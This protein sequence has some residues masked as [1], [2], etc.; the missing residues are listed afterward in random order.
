MIIL[1]LHE[2]CDKMSWESIK[3]CTLYYWYERPV[4][5]ESQI[6]FSYLLMDVPSLPHLGGKSEDFTS[7]QIMIF[8][9]MQ[10]KQ[11]VSPNKSNSVTSHWL[12]AGGETKAY[13][14]LRL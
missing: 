5:S 8:L 6:A 10:P 4:S 13:Q 1:R 11:S 14:Y 12:T 9:P 2:E 7:R 3:E